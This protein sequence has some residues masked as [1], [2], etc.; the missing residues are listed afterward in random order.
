MAPTPHAHPV[1]AAGVAVAADAVLT[2]L[3]AARLSDLLGLL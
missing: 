1:D 2:E 3:D